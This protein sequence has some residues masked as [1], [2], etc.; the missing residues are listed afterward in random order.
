MR[1]TENQIFEHIAR[2][3]NFDKKVV[4]LIISK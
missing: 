1:I 3:I 2:K 4:R